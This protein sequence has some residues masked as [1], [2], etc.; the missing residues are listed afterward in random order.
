[1]KKAITTLFFI[2][3]SNTGF[4]LEGDFTFR[5]SFNVEN[6]SYQAK[7]EL[8]KNKKEKYFLRIF[9]NSSKNFCDFYVKRISAPQQIRGLEGTIFANRDLSCKFNLL[10]EDESIF[11]NGIELIDVNYRFI[12]DYQLEG[13]LT[14]GS[15]KQTYRGLLVF[16]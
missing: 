11:W 7:I 2:I 14:L 5:G 12:K 8:V 16:E 9:P 4:S 10:S 3:I 13:R 1:M 6:M 15:I